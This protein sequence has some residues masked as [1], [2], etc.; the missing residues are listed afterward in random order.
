MSRVVLL[1]IVFD[2]DVPISTDG[3][4][5][6]CHSQAPQVTGV[7]DLRRP[8]RRLSLLPSFKT[9]PSKYRICNFRI[10]IFNVICSQ[11]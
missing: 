4:S 5:Y 1:D 7:W 8:R 10:L 9:A 11:L 6:T 2:V 3:T